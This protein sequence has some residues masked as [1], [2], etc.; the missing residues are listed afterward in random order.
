MPAATPSA[1][2][3]SSRP[4]ARP[5]DLPTTT[6]ACRPNA[7]D[8]GA[9]SRSVPAPKMMRAEV[10]NSKF[11]EVPALFVGEDVGVD[12]FAARLCL[13]RLHCLAPAFVVLGFLVALGIGLGAIDFDQH[14]AR[15]VIAL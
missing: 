14:E 4:R 2:N 13:Q 12:D 9:A 15:R 10:A 5:A 3:C 1:F 7:R 8:A 11:M 6:S